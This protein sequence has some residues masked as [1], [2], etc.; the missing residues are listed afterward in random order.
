LLD[1]I[2]FRLPD[3]GLEVQD[4]FDSLF[5]KDVV[6]TTDSLRKTQTPEQE[7]EPIK[8]DIRVRRSV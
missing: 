8:G 7:T 4:F 5:G 2:G 3:F 1:L 6:A